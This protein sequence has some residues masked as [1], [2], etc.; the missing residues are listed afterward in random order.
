MKKILIIGGMGPQAS[1]ILHQKIVEMSVKKGA[2]H[3]NDFPEVTHLSIPVPEFIDKKSEL[4]QA[5]QAIKE[6][7]YYLWRQKIYAYRY[8]M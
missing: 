3:G 4:R 8:C 1:L 5:L 6:Q 2:K 7:L